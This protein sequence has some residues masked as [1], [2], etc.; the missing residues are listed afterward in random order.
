MALRASLPLQLHISCEC[1]RSGLG[2]GGRGR[3][4]GE[5][6][7]GRARELHHLHWAGGGGGV[8]MRPES[9]QV[10]KVFPSHL[11]WLS[12]DGSGGSPKERLHTPHA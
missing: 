9:V 3:G 5:G 12:C 2:E 8:M 1:V 6:G 11:A 4:K 10:W 7:P